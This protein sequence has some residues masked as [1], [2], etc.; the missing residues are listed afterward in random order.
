MSSLR[1]SRGWGKRAVGRWRW[2]D[3]QCSSNFPCHGHPSYSSSLGCPRFTETYLNLFSVVLS[4]FCLLDSIYDEM[5]LALDVSSNMTQQYWWDSAQSSEFCWN[6]VLP[7]QLRI[8]GSFARRR[9][10]I[11]IPPP[12]QSSTAVSNGV[13][14]LS[15]WVASGCKLHLDEFHP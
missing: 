9:D 4:N 3:H 12:V 2:D 14:N 8:P 13:G 11:R 15:W 1:Q 10:F 7:Y 5:V 6:Q